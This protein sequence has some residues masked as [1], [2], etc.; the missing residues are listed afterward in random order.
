M[1]NIN[2][3]SPVTAK[4]AGNRLELQVGDDRDHVRVHL[5]IP[6]KKGELR[7]ALDTILDH[8]TSGLRGRIILEIS[9]LD[10][11]KLG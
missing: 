1:K 8:V 9:K 5:E 6:L 4:I 2:S 7:V 10:T 3:N 11:A